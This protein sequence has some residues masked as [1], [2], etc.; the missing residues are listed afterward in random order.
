M[1]CVLRRCESGAD[2]RRRLAAVGLTESVELFHA[3]NQSNG[4][5]VS[6]PPSWGDGD[7][8]G[9]GI[10]DSC[11]AVAGASGVIG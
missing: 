11:N 6:S 5:L 9:D 8:Y 3:D 10:L 2:E 7:D 1:C 4:M